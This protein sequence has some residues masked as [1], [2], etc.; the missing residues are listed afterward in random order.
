MYNIVVVLY[1][2]NS[3]FFTDTTYCFLTWFKLMFEKFQ[4]WVYFFIYKPQR[5]H[6]ALFDLL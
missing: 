3:I 1:I 6:F 2:N 5:L 4:M